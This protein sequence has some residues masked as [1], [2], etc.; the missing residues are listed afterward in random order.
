MSSTYSETDC[1][2]CA[3]EQDPAIRMLR[4]LVK[5]LLR[6]LENQEVAAMMTA[7]EMELIRKLLSDNSVTLASI[8]H[9]DFGK[10]A[11][12]VSEDFPFDD[13]GVLQ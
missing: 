13:E 7:A 9:G 8:R 6:R 3:D 4:G 12:S 5:E 10:I 11:Q 2:N 1:I